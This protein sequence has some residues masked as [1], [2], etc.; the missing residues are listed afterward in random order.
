M[1]QREATQVSGGQVAVA[2]MVMNVSSYGYTMLTARIVGP[3]E[4]GAFVAAL[5]LLLVIQVVALGLQATAARRIAANPDHVAAVE[6]SIMSLTLRV[7]LVLGSVLALL[8]PGI[9]RLLHLD[10][11]ATA[12]VIA[13]SAVP[14]TM[15]GGMMGVLQ[16]ERRW[17]ALSLMYLMGGVPRLVIGLAL[18]FW[19]PS[20][21]AALAGVAIGFVFPV[22]AGWWALRDRRSP[23]ESL[24][25][26]G[27]GMLVREIVHNSQALFAYFALSS[28]DIVVARNVLSA[29]DAGLYAGGLIVTKAMLFL[30]QFVV[31]VAFPSMAARSGGLGAVYRS[32][33]LVLVLGLVAAGTAWALSDVA[34]IFIGGGEFV[35]VESLLWIFAV[36][37]TLLSLVQFLV[38][39]TLARQGRRTALL[40]WGALVCLVALGINA[41]TVSGMVIVAL[42]VNSVLLVLLM[43]VTI[44]HD[45]AAVPQ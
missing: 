21:G 31:V 2:M 12:L 33:A 8:S 4:Y 34:M 15:A 9:N 45:R 32:M 24:P 28:V 37:G 42:S 35:E 36:L 7:A 16:G 27:F 41:T 25:E 14:L 6:T 23:Q 18:V 22:L 20:T 11:L 30:P 10:N 13:A 29:H 17:N 1:S 3:Q 19:M 5:N 39:A 38:Y 43:A 44:R 26:H 40:V